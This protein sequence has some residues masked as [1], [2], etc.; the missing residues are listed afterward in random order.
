MRSKR[1]IAIILIVAVLMGAVPPSFAVIKAQATTQQQIKDTE[2]DKKD[3][4]NK[5]DDQKDTI[6]DIK[7]EKKTLQEELTGLN[8]E[9]TK[10]SE[11]LEDL[12]NKILEKSQ[13]IEKT[14]Q[15]LE[16]AIETEKDQRE[17]VEMHVRKMYERNRSGYLT[18]LLQAGSLGKLLNLANWFERIE[19]YD[20]ETLSRYQVTKEFITRT[21]ERLVSEKADL[22]LLQTQAEAEKSRVAG[23]ISQVALKIEDYADQIE[24]AE[25]KALEYEAQIKAKEEDLKTL[26]K[27]LEE[28]I[29]LSQL[30]ANATWR[31][32][33]DVTFADG[34]RKL[35]AN[36][37]Y[38]EA[39]GES[40]EGKL[41]VGSVIINR[42]L[43]SKYPDTVVGVVYQK[44]QFSPAA[45]G[46][47]ELALA[48]DKA[49]ADCYKAADEA[50][51][52]KTNVG[53]CVYFRRPVPGLQGIVIGNHVFY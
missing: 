30:A 50:M 2:K 36:I 45:S 51:G 49:T 31:N 13:E 9:L 12:E 15:A 46:R 33:A 44:S 19:V 4:E 27:K 23:L 11:H 20:R 6:K 38:C 5:L 10:V 16:E 14:Q 35:L 26:K 43:S 29:R 21:E 41:A 3:L 53:T 1:K 52:G 8:A 24:E 25:K 32:I 37:I 28:E 34:D 22:D 17:S 7:K 48:T 42:M 47:L 18:S 40:Y 39:G